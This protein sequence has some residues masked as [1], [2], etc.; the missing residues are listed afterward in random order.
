M[1]GPFLTCANLQVELF[2]LYVR[3][4]ISHA[5]KIAGPPLPFSFLRCSNFLNTRKM[6][7]EFSH[8]KKTTFLQYIFPA[9]FFYFRLPSVHTS[10]REDEEEIARLEPS[11]HAPIV[12]YISSSSH[13][14]AFE[15]IERGHLWHQK[16]L[17]SILGSVLSSSSGPALFVRPTTQ[18]IDSKLYHYYCNEKKEEGIAGWLRPPWGVCFSGLLL[19]RRLLLPIPPLLPSTLVVVLLLLLLL[20]TPFQRKK[21]EGEKKRGKKSTSRDRETVRTEREEEGSATFVALFF[22]FGAT[23]L[24][25]LLIHLSAALPSSF[26]LLR[27]EHFSSVDDERVMTK[28]IDTSSFFLLHHNGPTNTLSG[29]YFP[30]QSLVAN[31]SLLSLGRRGE[32][33]GRLRRRPAKKRPWES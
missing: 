30:V 1:K 20:P 6:T 19:R 8:I 16:K 10:K 33:T 2:S 12:I 11:S 28:A 9:L 5:R 4:P 25:L 7:I 31:C 23:S 29:E 14:S 3:F 18:L 21:E 32:K 13:T 15:R 17:V 22:F 27:H 26:F 24:L